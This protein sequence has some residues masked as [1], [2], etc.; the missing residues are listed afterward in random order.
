MRLKLAL[1]VLPVLVPTASAVEITC[2]AGAAS[3]PVF[4]PSSV[5]GAVGDYTLDCTGGT[6]GSPT[7]MDFSS[8][9]NVSVLN[10]GGWILTDGV[11]NFA[12]TLV[13]GNLV[14]FLSVPFNPPG[15]GHLGLQVENIFVNPSVLP[16]GSQFREDVTVFGPLSITIVDPIQVV[17][18]NAPEAS[19]LL[20]AGMALGAV[21][22]L[23]C[24]RC[25]AVVPTAIVRSAER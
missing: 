14:E 2:N 17:A 21:V 3:I 22:W 16:P 19:T 9:M 12:G 24:R 20:L 7:L 18:V 8:F 25:H 15:V 1:W 11:N 6:P 23:G 4:N 13:D 10:T 5:S